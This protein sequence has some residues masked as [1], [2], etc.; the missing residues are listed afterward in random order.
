MRILHFHKVPRTSK[1]PGEIGVSWSFPVCPL[2][3]RIQV[4]QMGRRMGRS[5]PWGR[6][7]GFPPGR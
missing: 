3:P 1:N 4:R 7:K 2:P 6:W 5:G